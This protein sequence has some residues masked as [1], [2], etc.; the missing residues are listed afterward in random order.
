MVQDMLASLKI[1]KRKQLMDNSFF[2]IK[3][4]LSSTR[5]DLKIIY[6]MAKVLKRG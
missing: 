1:I 5:G 6:I 3:I 2:K 4:K